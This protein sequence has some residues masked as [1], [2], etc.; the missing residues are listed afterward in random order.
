MDEEEVTYGQK[1][2]RLVLT[3]SEGSVEISV[4]RTICAETEEALCA[5]VAEAS[6]RLLEAVPMDAVKKTSSK[7]NETDENLREPHPVVVALVGENRKM[8]KELTVL[9]ASITS[10]C[11]RLGADQ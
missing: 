9:N 4:E 8:V 1:S 2:A 7:I 10:L 6:R 11:E 5:Q 3:V